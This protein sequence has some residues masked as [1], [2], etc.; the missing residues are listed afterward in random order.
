MYHDTPCK[1]KDYRTIGSLL[2]KSSASRIL[3][4][5]SLFVRAFNR[6]VV[7]ADKDRI[8]I[9]PQ[10]AVVSFVNF[11]K[12]PL[13]VFDVRFGIYEWVAIAGFSGNIHAKVRPS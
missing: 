2:N 1:T 8:R 10:V 9:K 13:V 6:L 12:A 3:L 5:L 4:M 11:R 7:N